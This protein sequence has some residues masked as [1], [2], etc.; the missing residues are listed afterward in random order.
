[1]RQRI[2]YA[3]A[4]TLFKLI[5][6]LPRPLARAAG[7][8]LGYFVYLRHA[9]LRHVGMRNLALAFPE[10]SKHERAKILRGEFRSLGRQVAEVSLFPKYTAKNVTQVIVYD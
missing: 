2:E 1:M 10:K 3:V 9:R 6:S 7:I 8:T 5:G 4:W